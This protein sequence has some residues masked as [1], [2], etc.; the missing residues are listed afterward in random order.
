MNS[1][2]RVLATINHRQPDRVPID[3]GATAGTGINVSAYI[4]LCRALG[5]PL[6]DVRV[7]DVFLAMYEAVREWGQYPITAP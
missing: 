6:S 2:E 3:L 5:L 7:N 1:R 4:R